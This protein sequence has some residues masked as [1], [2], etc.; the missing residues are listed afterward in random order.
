MSFPVKRQSVFSIFFVVS[1]VSIF[2]IVL[3]A[4][5]VGC[6]QRES[7]QELKEKTAKATENAKRDIK[8]VADG[9]RE[10]WNSDKDKNGQ[11]KDKDKQVNLNTASKGRLLTLPGMTS[12]EADRVIAGRPYSE[13]DEVV[14]RNIMPKTKYDRI[15]GR[16]TTQD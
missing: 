10:G 16:V 14:T 6:N 4:V 12:A 1:I 15:A 2:A 5:L 13:P 3:M 8:A 7:P 11:D 9:V